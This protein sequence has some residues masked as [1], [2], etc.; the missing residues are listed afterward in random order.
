MKILHVACML[1]P[2]S[3]IINQML[4]EFQAASE[5]N[6]DLDVRIFTGFQNLNNEKIFVHSTRTYHKLTLLKKVKALFD[7]KREYYNWLE[8]Q[9]KNYDIIL[10]RYSVHDLGLL[11]FV[12]KYK[13]KVKILTVHHTLETP[14]LK[15]LGGIN[16]L[17][18]IGD[19]IIGKKVLKNVHGIVSVT[20]EI[21][22]FEKMR[23][24]DL[25]NLTSIIYPN[26]I[27]VNDV[28]I[29]DERDKNQLNIV[30]VASFF[31]EWH[32]LDLLLSQLEKSEYSSLTVHIVGL[33]SDSDF[34]RLKNITCI[35]YHGLLNSEELSKLYEKCDI[36]LASF[37][38][39]RKSMNQACTLKVREYLVN[40]LAVYSGHQ[41]VFGD[42]FM[43]YHY[44]ELDIEEIIEFSL[45]IKS[46][47]KDEIVQ[48]SKKYI[49]KRNLLID[50]VEKLNCV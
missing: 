32:G 41:D 11:K 27:I 33:M 49:D 31:Y 47:S 4:D 36:G 24:T 19:E 44:G 43:L 10:L 42:N 23:R 20:N 8:S 35:R 15:M 25:D 29:S 3:G 1:Y 6:I 45:K 5:L 40:G 9:I 2:T 34:N 26:G 38:L 50:L 22:Q 17:R 30:F 13:N 46:K 18:G 14:E 37:A 12:S 16:Y 7:L 39:Y 21:S 28:N 48:A